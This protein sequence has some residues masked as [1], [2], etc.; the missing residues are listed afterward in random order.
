MTAFI[1]RVGQ[2][3]LTKRYI[4]LAVVAALVLMAAVPAFAQEAPSIQIDPTPI[5]DG[6]ET[7]APIFFAIFAI[8]GGILIAIV[9]VRMI[10]NAIVNAFRGSS[11]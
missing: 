2:S 1:H 6:I 10:I 4:L 9:L 8:P 5:F 7:Y 11:I 3:R